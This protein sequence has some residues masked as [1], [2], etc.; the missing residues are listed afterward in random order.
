[1]LAEL[2]G[3]ALLAGL[4]GIAAGYA[5]AAA[6]LP[7]VAAS[8]RGLYGARVPGSLSLS[9]AWWPAGLAISL[10]GAL[11]AAGAS[12]WR[13]WTLPLLAPAQPQAWLA[14]QR[15]GLRLQLG[16]AAL[17]APPPSPPS[18]SAAASPP[19]SR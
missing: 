8:L 3:L 14:A 9:P 16:L 2:L 7:D 5:L 1:M 11:A 10:A 15:R 6:L 4:A 12:L 13:A 18:P 19:A 17:L